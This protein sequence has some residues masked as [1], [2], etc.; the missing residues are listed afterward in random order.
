[1]ETAS[2]TYHKDLNSPKLIY[3]FSIIP[4]KIP[5]RFF[6]ELKKPNKE[7]KLYFLKYITDR[8]TL[9]IFFCRF[10]VFNSN[11]RKKESIKKV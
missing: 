3:A 10:S 9:K 4:I 5:R 6:T 8:N 1:M 2:Q 11:L 7:N